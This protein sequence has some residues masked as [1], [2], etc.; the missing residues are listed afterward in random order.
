MEYILPNFVITA[1]KLKYA[2]WFP[3]GQHRFQLKPIGL[4]EGRPEVRPHKPHAEG[5]KLL[6]ICDQVNYL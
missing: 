6:K 1:I 2:G 3:R 5:R 4:K